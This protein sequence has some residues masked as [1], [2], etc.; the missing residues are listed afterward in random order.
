[1]RKQISQKSYNCHK[2]NYKHCRILS[3]NEDFLSEY[4]ETSSKLHY[5]ITPIQ[6]R[7]LAF[8]YAT[9]NDKKVPKSWKTEECTGYE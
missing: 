5:R 2:S 1:M 8:Q 6:L 9:N 4:L 3:A 7:K